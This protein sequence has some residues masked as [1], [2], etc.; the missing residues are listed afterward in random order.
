MQLKLAKNSEVTPWKIFVKRPPLPIGNPDPSI[1]GGGC[2]H[3]KWN[4]HRYHKHIQIQ[5]GSGYNQTT[6]T[7]GTKFSH[8]LFRIVTRSLN[9]TKIIQLLRFLLTVRIGDIGWKIVPS[10]SD[11]S[12]NMLVIISLV[13]TS[14]SLIA[15]YTSG[16]YLQ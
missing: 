15:F 1:G 16:L 3:I 14:I 13:L 9:Y 11:I 7:H 12:I 4:A 5:T 6:F 2:A 8:Y 10:R